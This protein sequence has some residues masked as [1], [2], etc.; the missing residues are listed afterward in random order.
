MGNCFS[1]PS[2]PP[3]KGQ[4]LGST[5][6][7]PAQSSST[8]TTTQPSPAGGRPAKQKINSPPPRTLGA[9]GGGGDAG[10]PRERA[11]K[12]AEERAKSVS[13]PF[14]HILLASDHRKKIQN[15]AD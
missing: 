3:G 14:D 11:L 9:P 10:D 5:P 6:S 1:D 8:T 4:T 12:A 15:E 7:R 2:K 13:S